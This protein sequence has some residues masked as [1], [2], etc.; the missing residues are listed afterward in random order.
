MTTNSHNLDQTLAEQRDYY[1]ARAQEYDEW[2]LRQGRFDHGEEANALWR[3]EIATMHSALDSAGISGDVL[4]LA[5][6]TG[7]WTI[8][9]ARLASHVTALDASAEMIAINRARLE[10]AG[11]ADRVTLQ[12]VDLFDWQP[13]G[14]YDAV[15]MGFFLSHVPVELEDALLSAVV[16]SLAP[17]GKVFFADSK[18]EPT[19]TA[20]D[21]PLPDAGAQVMS[22]KLNDGRTFQVIKLYRSVAEMTDL[23]T[24]HGVSID[25]QETPRYFQYGCGEKKI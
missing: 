5:P 11:L 19:S 18:R 8:Q 10:D 25:V 12:Q 14:T 17:G 21:Q 13:D 16:T 24:R 2:W 4:E 1:D 20:P 15:V 7:N 22:R 23:F 6:G 9:L 3:D